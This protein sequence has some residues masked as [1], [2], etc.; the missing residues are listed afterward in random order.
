MARGHLSDVDREQ[1]ALFLPERR[2]RVVSLNEERRV[3]DRGRRPLGAT[4]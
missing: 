1:L 4:A 2:G 3:V